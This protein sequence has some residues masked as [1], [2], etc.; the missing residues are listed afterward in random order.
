M[1]PNLTK[2]DEKIIEDLYSNKTKYLLN[3]YLE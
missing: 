3:N 2:S 1:H